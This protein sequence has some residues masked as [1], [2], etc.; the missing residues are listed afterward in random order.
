MKLAFIRRERASTLATIA[1]P[2]IAF[3]LSILAS[4]V[5]FVVL[6][7]PA[8]QALYSLLLEPFLTW[9]T[10]SEVL[11]KMTPLL[12]IA[13]GLAIGF[14]ANVFNIG[15][16]GQLII[17]AIA[18]SALPVWFPEGDSILMLPCD[19]R[20]GRLGRYGMGGIGCGFAHPLQCQ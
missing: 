15:A 4:L 2:V 6:G 20:D 10:F 7:K 13:Q 1:A 18:A 9:Y 8:G 19:D 11:L 5:L 12:L 14:R 16:E 3:I 17:G